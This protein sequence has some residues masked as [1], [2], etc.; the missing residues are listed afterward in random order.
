M[1]PKITSSPIDAYHVGTGAAMNLKRGDLFLGANGAATS[2]GYPWSGLEREAF[3]SG[4][5]D[6]IKVLYPRGVLVDIEGKLIEEPSIGRARKFGPDGMTA[7]RS[8]VD[9][10]KHELE[11]G[12]KLRETLEWIVEL[13]EA[14][15]R[16]EEG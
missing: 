7:L 13:A 15:I 3:I 6:I 9:S 16:K 5:L 4:Y 2:A 12:D 8:I 14:A 10:A 1:A 11:A